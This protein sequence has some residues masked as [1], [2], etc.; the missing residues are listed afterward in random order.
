MAVGLHKCGPAVWIQTRWSHGRVMLLPG[1]FQP[2]APQT[3]FC[4]ETWTSWWRS[5]T[6]INLS[7]W[8]AI[9]C[10]PSP[11]RLLLYHLCLIHFVEWRLWGILWADPGGSELKAIKTILLRL[12]KRKYCTPIHTQTHAVIL[13]SFKIEPETYNS[14]ST[15]LTNA[16]FSCWIFPK[17]IKWQF[18]INN[19]LSTEL[20]GYFNC[21]KS[22]F[23]HLK[24]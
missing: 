3:Y 7:G 5:Q 17:P 2:A 1:R 19:N 23:Y 18:I 22:L 15:W 8:T 16:T 24:L 14:Y 4:K 9:D 20:M 10:N 12:S 11:C 21:D 13:F 6:P